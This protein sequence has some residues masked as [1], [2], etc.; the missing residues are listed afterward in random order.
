MSSR[1]NLLASKTA[2]LVNTDLVFSAGWSPDYGDPK[3][4][5]DILDPDNGDLLKSFG[6]N[7]SAIQSQ[8]EKE[9]KEQ[10]GLY[11]FKELK[12]AANLEVRDMD[13]RY[14]RYADAEAY[15]LDQAYFIPLYASGGSYAVSRII[16]YTKSYSPYGLSPMKFKR[17]QLSDR[18]VTLEERNKRYEKWSTVRQEQL[19]S[20]SIN[21]AV[22]N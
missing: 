21:G 12:E 7:R 5:L 18:I 16:P 3:S 19:K 20:K 1:E 4:Y 6:L 9:L 11:V 15:A 8:E 2:E 14:E 10:I 13:K 22:E 17:M